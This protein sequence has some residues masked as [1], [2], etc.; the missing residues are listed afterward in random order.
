MRNRRREK[1]GWFIAGLKPTKDAKPIKAAGQVV[2]WT[3]LEGVT[4]LGGRRKQVKCPAC[5]TTN[6]AR[7]VVTF[8]APG[9][10]P[11]ATVG[12]DQIYAVTWRNGQQMWQTLDAVPDSQEYTC[13]C[14][15]TVCVLLQ[16]VA[17]RLLT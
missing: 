3:K 4:R 10:D 11:R 13:K 1:E 2:G 12:S 16:E 6:R 9:R 5:R 8:Y 7:T 17:G 14:G 15:N